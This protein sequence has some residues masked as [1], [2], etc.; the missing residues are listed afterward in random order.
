MKLLVIPLLLL[1]TGCVSLHPFLGARVHRFTHRGQD[2]IH[3]SVLMSPSQPQ[4]AE[5][6][7]KECQDALAERP[8]PYKQK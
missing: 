2:Y 3:C 7:I 5:D 6:A 1:T 4:M 8:Q